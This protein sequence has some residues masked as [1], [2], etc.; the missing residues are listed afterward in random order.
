M[1]PY[2]DGKNFRPVTWRVEDVG[3][4]NTKVIVDRLENINTQMRA[5]D[6]RS[7][8]MEQQLDTIAQRLKSMA[9]D[10]R[11]GPLVFGNINA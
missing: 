5:M 6:E 8:R 2:A 11:M 3:G 4:D 1:P 7:A 10:R 9:K